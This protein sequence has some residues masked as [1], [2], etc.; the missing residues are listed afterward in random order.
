MF[1]KIVKENR[2]PLKAIKATAK[3]RHVEM[4]KILG[5]GGGAATYET[6]PATMGRRGRKFFISN[7]LK[8]LEKEIFAGGK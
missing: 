2:K 6:L 4:K 1:C 7:R 8:R 3:H 5:G